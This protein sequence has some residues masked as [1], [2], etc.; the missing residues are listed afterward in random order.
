[1]NVGDLQ[2]VAKLEREPSVLELR[3]GSRYLLHIKQHLPE[4][5]REHI[6]HSLRDLNVTVICIPEDIALYELVPSAEGAK[7]L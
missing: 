6:R 4:V 7:T 2:S 5:F 1:M 3:P